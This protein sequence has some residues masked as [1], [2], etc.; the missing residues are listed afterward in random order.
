MKQGAIAAI[1]VVK[2]KKNN[3]WAS[4]AEGVIERI[5]EKQTPDVDAVAGATVTSEGIQ[6]AVKDALSKAR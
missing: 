3:S 2:N 1:D 5:I 6:M 4:Q